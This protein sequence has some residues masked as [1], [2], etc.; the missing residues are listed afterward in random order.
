MRFRSSHST[1]SPRRVD[2]LLLRLADGNFNVI[3]GYS[4]QDL[5]DMVGCVRES[6]TATLVGFKATGAVAISRKK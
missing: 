4:H 5:A 1:T 2:A 3:E 6:L